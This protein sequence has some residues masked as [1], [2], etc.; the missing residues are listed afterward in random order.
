M[1]EGR[2]SWNRMWSSR[3]LIKR[4]GW[5]NGGPMFLATQESLSVFKKG[6]GFKQDEV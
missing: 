1:R 6:K 5:C 3:T 4:R 2:N